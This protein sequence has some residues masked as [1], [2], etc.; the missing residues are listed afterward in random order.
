MK[1][2]INGNEIEFREICYDDLENY[3]K[4]TRKLYDDKSSPLK[5][6]EL[7]LKTIVNLSE[8]NITLEQIKKLAKSEIVPLINYLTEQLDFSTKKKE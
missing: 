1:F 8:G 6:I 2:N 7:N 5:Y 4:E 3:H